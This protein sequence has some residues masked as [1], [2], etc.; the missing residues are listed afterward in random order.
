MCI[1]Y[2][3]Q[4]YMN[5]RFK[6]LFCELKICKTYVNLKFVWK[7]HQQARLLASWLIYAILATLQT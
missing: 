4:I 2:H 1:L 5:T 6:L 3:T 7:L